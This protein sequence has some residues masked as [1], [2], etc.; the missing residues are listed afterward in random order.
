MTLDEDCLMIIIICAG[1]ICI[2]VNDFECDMPD[3]KMLTDGVY[4]IQSSRV[5]VADRIRIYGLIT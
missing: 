1:Q 3:K 5:T 2:H 4:S